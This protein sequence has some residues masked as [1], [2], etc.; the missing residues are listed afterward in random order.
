MSKAMKGCRS[1]QYRHIYR[2]TEQGCTHITR[3]EIY[4]HAGAKLNTLKSRP[5]RTQRYFIVAATGIV[6]PGGGF[7]TS[8]GKSFII[9]NVERFQRNFLPIMRSAHFDNTQIALQSHD[10]LAF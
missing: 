1:Y 4:K 6:I 5:V 7:H 9:K 3:A 2:S 10:L 8:H